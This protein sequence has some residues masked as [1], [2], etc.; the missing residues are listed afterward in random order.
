MIFSNVCTLCQ[1][2]LRLYK[3][4]KDYI[5]YLKVIVGM[6]KGYCKAIYVTYGLL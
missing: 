4:P 1:A 2:Y 6:L 5:G 3:L